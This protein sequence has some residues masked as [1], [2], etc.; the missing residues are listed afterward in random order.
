MSKAA[1]LSQEVLW[2]HEKGAAGV[3]SIGD[4]LR[5]S[6]LLAS[7]ETVT[8]VIDS[9]NADIRVDQ[10]R[11]YFPLDYLGHVRTTL[12]GE[13]LWM[14]IPFTLQ[15]NSAASSSGLPTLLLLRFCLRLLP[16]L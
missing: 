15:V 11:S 13:A 10:H 5:T 14:V 9:Y 6:S 4:G 7:S 2:A 8:V 3:S 12:D 16:R 1:R